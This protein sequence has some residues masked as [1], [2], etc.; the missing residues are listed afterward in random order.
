MFS[1]TEIVLL[2]VNA[3]KAPR[4][5]PTHTHFKSLKND[6]KLTWKSKKFIRVKT[7]IVMATELMNALADLASVNIF[8]I[9]FTE[10]LQQCWNLIFSNLVYQNLP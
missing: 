8:L 7:Y 5:P 3:Q 1:L 6:K 9:H 10:E 2:D 4:F